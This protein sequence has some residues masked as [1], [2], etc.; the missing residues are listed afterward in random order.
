[1][2]TMDTDVEMTDAPCGLNSDNNNN[3]TTCPE[4]RVQEAEDVDYI[5]DESSFYGTSPPFSPKSFFVF[6][7]YTTPTRLC[8]IGRIKNKI[9]AH[10][11][12]KK[13][14]QGGDDLRAE[15]ERRAAEYDPDSYWH[16]AHLSLP[17]IAAAYRR[18]HTTSGAQSSSTPATQSEPLY[19]PHEGDPSG[20]Q[21]SESIPEFL[22]RL[23]ASTTLTSAAGPWIWIANPYGAG[24]RLLEQDLAGLMEDGTRV[25]D[26]C[27][28]TMAD[29]QARF[30]GLPGTLLARHLTTARKAATDGILAAARTRGVTSGKWMLFPSARDV[31]AVWRVV[32]DATATGQLGSG[33]KVA[34]K[35]AT[36]EDNEPTTSQGRVP[37]PRPRLI[38][39][40]TTDFA[41]EPDVTRVVR[42]LDQ[43]GLV[44]KPGPWG[45]ET[46]IYYKCGQS[47][48][49]LSR[50]SPSPSPL[51][52]PALHH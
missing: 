41:D 45:Q 50:L 23:P 30:T 28:T 38:C 52:P 2:K 22:A 47:F 51:S 14:F 34:T 1:M 43:L 15:L 10:I 35:P 36:E 7:L 11:L 33:A 21:L 37:R 3:V 5:S 20:R 13:N 8:L 31:D 42:K 32:A 44:R 49:S 4:D 24:P 48:F 12:E 27:G 25:L 39:V 26:S 19:N 40:Y 46:G 17:A 18:S 6:L 9:Y 29:K 16:T